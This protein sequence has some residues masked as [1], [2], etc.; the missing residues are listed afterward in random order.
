M[1]YF[2]ENDATFIKKES[3]R[4][5]FGATGMACMFIP[6]NA[7]NNAFRAART[8]AVK[9]KL[10]VIDE[11]SVRTGESII[12]VAPSGSGKSTF[13]QRTGYPFLD[14]DTILNFPTTNR[15]FDDESVVQSVN[16]MHSEDLT[17]RK[18]RG[19]SEVILYVEHPSPD[20]I[21]IIDEDAHKDR[22]ASRTNTDQP[23][24]ADWPRIQKSRERLL[25]QAS[26][27]NI[28]VL[29]EFDEIPLPYL[30]SSHKMWDDL[31]NVAANV[32]ASGGIVLFHRAKTDLDA[33]YMANY[34]WVEVVG[35]DIP[36]IF[37]GKP[38]SPK[39]A[40]VQYP[41]FETAAESAGHLR[42]TYTIATRRLD[43]P[44]HFKNVSRAGYLSTVEG[45]DPT[46]V[47]GHD[48]TENGI[49]V[50]ISGHFLAMMV[51]HAGGY[52]NPMMMYMDHIDGNVKLSG[53]RKGTRLLKVLRPILT[54][55]SCANPQILWHRKRDYYL[56]VGFY[57]WLLGDD[58]VTEI[59]L[60]WLNKDSAAAFSS[61][62]SFGDL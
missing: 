1:P 17:Q 11:T 36:R 29:S 49:G 46:P 13:I 31:W 7:D 20:Y 10:A 25:A 61:G 26:S 51:L 42:H 60:E 18:A 54:E 16:E 32:G 34:R 6:F 47:L 52:P 62:I 5:A 8:L 12:V 39:A 23:G 57:K 30:C 27:Q 24:I 33:L 48:G 35:A 3:K 21:I 2:T 56:T 44:A 9:S 38:I 4:I 37:E 45:V 53:M 40:K 19:L 50:S 15:W 22:L 41:M 58:P 43:L 14:A 55:D 28:P 59:A